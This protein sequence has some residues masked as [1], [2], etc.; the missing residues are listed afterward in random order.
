MKLNFNAA[1]VAPVTLDTQY[2][3]T[4]WY[5]LKITDSEIKPTSTNNGTILAITLEVQAGAYKGARIIENL[6][7]QNPNEKAVKIGQGMLSTI[8]HAVGQL[9]L[10]D[11]QQ[12][13][14]ISFY[15][16]LKLEPPQGTY[17]PRNSLV[18]AKSI[19]ETVD[20]SDKEMP[21]FETPKQE[22]ASTS[23]F[24]PA[25]NAAPTFPTANAATNAA[26]NAG[27]DLTANTGA[28]NKEPAAA[29]TFPSAN[30]TNAGSFDPGAEP[31]EVPPWAK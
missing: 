14:N 6:N 17:Q 29:P 1:N 4:N 3:P 28:V 11:S 18:N 2:V 8:C 24:K 26:T 20:I 10:V 31:T 22:S 7:L 23:A 21:V 16:K 5:G 30:T 15:G 19:K 13:H 9:N 12:L 25:A 27:V